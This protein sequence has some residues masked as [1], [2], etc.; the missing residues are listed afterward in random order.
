MNKI[1]VQIYLD[2]EQ[3]RVLTHLSK[4]QNRSKG[5]IIRACIQEFLS[6]LPPEQ[7]PILDIVGLGESGHSDLSEKHDDYLCDLKD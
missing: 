3:D 5:A 1:A 7:D 2:P 4:T 6:R